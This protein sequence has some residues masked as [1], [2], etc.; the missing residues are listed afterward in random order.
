[1]AGFDRSG[2][3]ANAVTTHTQLAMLCPMLR[4]VLWRATVTTHR[5]LGIAVGALMLMWFISGMVMMYVPYPQ[6][7]PAQHLSTL[8]PIPLNTCCAAGAIKLADDE[9]IQSLQIETLLGQPVTRIRPDGRPPIYVALADGAPVAIDAAKARTIALDVAPRIT[10]QSSALASSDVIDRDQWTVAEDYEGD[11]PMYRFSYNDPRR[12]EAY[13][14]SSSGEVVLWT[15]GAQRFWNWLGAVPHW[16]YFTQLRSNGPLWSKIVIW[17]SIAGG[18]L[19]TLGLY[20]GVMQFGRGT[21]MSPYRG[22]QMWHHLIG[23][24]FGVFALAWVVSGTI[25]M[26]PWGFLEGRGG[27]ERGLLSGEPLSWSAYRNSLST[28]TRNASLAGAVSLTGAPQ[29]GKLFWL[30]RWPDGKILRL[31][32]EGNAAPLQFTELSRLAELV[33]GGRSIESAVLLNSE[34]SYYYRSVASDRLSLP[35]YRVT[36]SDGER[37]RYY[38]DPRTGAL[39]GRIDSARRGYRWLFDGLHHLDFFA[40]MRWRPLWD[41]IVLLLLFG[42]IGVT[43]TGCYLAISRIRRDLRSAAATFSA[44]VRSASE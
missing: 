6:L 15:T 26:N 30:A 37:T 34:D 35:V 21:R 28:L 11:R 7:S 32:A 2:I 16:L 25:S 3:F 29:D 17:T 36:L 14:S 1:V 41:V 44:Q 33:A 13:I 24:I 10:G 23:L 19:T 5:Y 40:W 43:S 18:F 12:T 9:P 27:N 22:W 20:L 42:G 31:N 8:P 39:M 38:F 4:S